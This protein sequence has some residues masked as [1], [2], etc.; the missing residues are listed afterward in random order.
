MKSHSYYTTGM[1]MTIL[2]ILVL[3]AELTFFI[4]FS[5]FTLSL[6]YSSLKGSPYVPTRNREVDEIL[7]EVKLK[8]GV[9]FYELGSGDA[10]I[11]RRVAKRFAVNAVAVDINPLLTWYARHLAK[12]QKIKNVEFRTENIFTTDLDDADV[13]YLFLMPALIQKLRPKLEKELKTATV[14]ISHGFK[15]EGFEKKLFHTLHHKPFATYYY[16][17]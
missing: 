14:I 13:V 3:L 9:K 7:Q 6:I 17:I 15:I 1:V 10:R 5:I 16:R 12:F 2:Y 11:A 8:G 4:G